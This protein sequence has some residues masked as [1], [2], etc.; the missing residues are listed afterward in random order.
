M[1]EH[2]AGITASDGPSELHHHGDASEIPGSPMHPADH[3]CFQCQ[4]L[5]HMSH[6]FL[7]QPGVPEIAFPF[8]SPVQPRARVDTEFRAQILGLPLARGPPLPPT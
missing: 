7:V 2:H 6:G 4:V 3:D 8:G 1:S 5:K